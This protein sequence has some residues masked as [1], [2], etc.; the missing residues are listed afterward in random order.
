MY[1]KFKLSFLGFLLFSFYCFLFCNPKLS[2]KK[3]YLTESRQDA[4]KSLKKMIPE[5]REGESPLEHGLRN[6]FVK[7]IL[8]QAKKPGFFNDKE[9]EKEFNKNIDQEIDKELREAK[10]DNFD[11]FSSSGISEE[12][13][14]DGK[15]LLKDI[16]KDFIKP[17]VQK[18]G[19]GISKDDVSSFTDLTKQ[20][21]K[22]GQPIEN[23]T[24]ILDSILAEGVSLVDLLKED[25]IAINKLKNSNND[26]ARTVGENFDKYIAKLPSLF[27]LFRAKVLGPA[28][29]G[30]GIEKYSEVFQKQISTEKSIESYI[31]YLDLEDI[32]KLNRIIKKYPYIE[33]DESDYIQIKEWF[34]P[35]KFN[36]TFNSTSPLVDLISGNLFN[37]IKRMSL[38][39]IKHFLP[40]QG[41]SKDINN[42]YSQKA[43]TYD[44]KQC[45]IQAIIKGITVSINR[46]KTKIDEVEFLN[47]KF[48][49]DLL[50]DYTQ[51]TNKISW[52]DFLSELIF[53]DKNEL[54][55]KDS[56]KIDVIAPLMDSS[57]SNGPLQKV[58]LL[59]LQMK[60]RYGKA[61]GVK[62]FSEDTFDK[63][64]DKMLECLKQGFL[65]IPLLY[66]PNG[67]M[68]YKPCIHFEN[69]KFYFDDSDHEINFYNE[70][71]LE[72]LMTYKSSS[73]SNNLNDDK[74]KKQIKMFIGE[75]KE[76][77]IIDV[78]K[79]FIQENTG[80][81]S[82]NTS[83]VKYCF[84]IA[85]PKNRLLI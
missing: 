20:F 44:N 84:I 6:P 48:I 65:P 45:G 58:G 57:I 24:E 54:E 17:L 49:L 14:N 21:K 7:V 52:N 39:N 77:K 42:K 85:D 60:K 64:K 63:I 76:N 4:E 80:G 25:P 1:S 51:A 2:N 41:F 31:A 15:K 37:Y 56:K 62:Y 16:T 53:G 61:L 23:I 29:M 34:G 3:Q 5:I 33:K 22:K 83:S 47:N 81:P 9:N 68:H 79:S 70:S 30:P 75:G 11:L 78:I 69:G 71:E 67:G 40:F 27:N 35:N 13:F 59:P 10:L 26:I 8:D 43:K 72:Q 32:P 82:N 19:S 74:T 36:F 50:Y 46:N 66:W 12:D 55:E 28:G 18:K 73:I 38:N